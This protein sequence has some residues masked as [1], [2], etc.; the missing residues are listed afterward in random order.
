MTWASRDEP[1]YDEPAPDCQGHHQCDSPATH[2]WHVRFA[3]G[4]A[5]DEWL[6]DE[7]EQRYREVDWVLSITE[8]LSESEARQRHEERGL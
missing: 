6:C 1:G 2:R 8:A 5:A 7:H 4:A 3:S